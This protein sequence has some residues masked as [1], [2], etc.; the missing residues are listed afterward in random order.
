MTIVD[1]NGVLS[2]LGSYEPLVLELGCGNRKRLPY[3]IGIDALDYEAVDIVGDVFDVLQQFPN[4]SVDMITTHHFF[5]HIEDLN[6]LMTELARV[7]VFNGKIEIVVPHFSNPYFY[8]DPTHRS[9]FGL[10][11]FSYYAVAPFLKRTV[12]TYQRETRFELLQIDLISVS[13]T[14]SPSPRDRQKSRMP[15]SA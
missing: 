8:S 15:S 6:H 11:T 14:H 1:K 5:E 9:F 12:P 7:M 2:K 4:Q 13:Y 3:S 10:Y